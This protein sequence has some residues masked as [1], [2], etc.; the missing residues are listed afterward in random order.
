MRAKIKGNQTPS[1]SST[2]QFV[3]REAT[4]IAPLQVIVMSGF[5]VHLVNQNTEANHHKFDTNP[6]LN[7]YIYAIEVSVKEILQEYPAL[8]KPYYAQEPP[9]KQLNYN[10]YK[11]R[12]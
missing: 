3:V 1:F 10:F 8:Q 9:R 5:T 6:I 4:K 2:R 12:K 11:S 7:L